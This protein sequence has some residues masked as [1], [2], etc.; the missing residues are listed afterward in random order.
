MLC[1]AS[2]GRA[3]TAPR[4]TDTMLK[5][6]LILYAG[7]DW[8]AD[9]RTSSHHLSRRLARQNR[10]LY[11]EASGGRAPRASKRDLGRIVA[12]L[13]KSFRPPEAVAPN[14][15]VYSPLILPF[16]RFRAVRWLNRWL[17][18]V[19]LRRA[20]RRLGFSKPLIWMAV[21]HYAAMIDV[22]PSSGIVYYCVDEY[23]SLPNTDARATLDMESHILDR[24]DVVFV[25]S[26]KLLETKRPKNAHTYLNL[27]GVE[28]DHF[29]RAARD[30]TTVPDDIAAIPKPIAG[31]FGLVEEWVDL[32]LVRMAATRNPDVSFV[33]VGRVAADV[34]ALRGLANVHFLGQRKYSDLPA[35]L[36]A[37]DV[38][39][40]PFKLTDVIVNSNPLK[41]KE[42]LAGGK[43]VVTVKIQPLT[44]YADVAYIADGPDAFCDMIARAIAEDTPAKREARMRAMAGESWDS[45][46]EF[47]CE[48]VR[49]HIPGER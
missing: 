34:A 35:Y 16:H 3:H 47:V 9:N 43:P 25:I 33:F 48:K 23:A 14:V 8:S 45:K 4:P 20:C 27:H 41:F 1:A 5:D 36:K 11:I 32:E 10:L 12:K 22:V 17:L 31:F 30:D 28:T 37:F 21:P 42:Y 26:E 7:N 6:E 29:A 49:Q 39:L 44:P 40:I 13:R 15:H 2:G 18:R 24:A 38:A 19:S 46:F